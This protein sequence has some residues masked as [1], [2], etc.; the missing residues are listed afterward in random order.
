M[1]NNKIDEASKLIQ[2]AIKDYDLFLKEVNTYTP[3]KK[4]EALSWLRNTLRYINDK[5]NKDK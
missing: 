2:L 1:D 4:A 3:E 5:K